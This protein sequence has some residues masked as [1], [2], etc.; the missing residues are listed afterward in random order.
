MSESIF[1]E[2]MEGIVARFFLT[3]FLCLKVGNSLT[4]NSISKKSAFH[5]RGRDGNPDLQNVTRFT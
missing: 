3:E 4:L 2:L 1:Q 5:Y